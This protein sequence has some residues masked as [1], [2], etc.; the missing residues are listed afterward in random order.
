ME[1]QT[2]AISP[3][4]LYSVIATLFSIVLILVGI[5]WNISVREKVKKLEADIENLKPR[6]QHIEDVHGNGRERLETKIDEFKKEFLDKLSEVKEMVHR[7]KN[8][9]QQLNT[10]MG[11]ILKHLTKD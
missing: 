11:A 4:M 3:T 2:I 5:V 9:E 8:V 7:D 10:T 6:V 1:P